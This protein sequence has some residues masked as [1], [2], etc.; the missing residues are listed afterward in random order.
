MNISRLL[1]RRPNA[2][3]YRHFGY[4]GTPASRFIACSFRPWWGPECVGRTRGQC[5]STR[6]S[7]TRGA[8]G[9]RPI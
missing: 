9:R 7:S 5:D 1:A 8:Q 4:F 6:R 3:R 2:R